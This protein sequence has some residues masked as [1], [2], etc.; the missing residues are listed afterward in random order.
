MIDITAPVSRPGT[1][2]RLRIWAKKHPL[3]AVAAAVAAVG[4]TGTAA[5][6]YWTISGAGQGSGQAANPT[7]AV[8]ITATIATPI[9][10]GGSHTV[11]T[12]Q[13]T[14]TNTSAVTVRTLTPTAVTAWNEV[15]MTTSAAACQTLLDSH[16]TGGPTAAA[17]DNWVSMAAV[18]VNT[19]VPAS[20]TNFALTG[21]TGTLA[22]YNDPSV[23]QDACKDKYFKVTFTNGG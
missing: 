5:F 20:S 3:L 18:A 22:F 11:N 6:A 9:Y 2:L 13:A 12:F 8:T 14:N 17:A 4:L 7:T 1:R 16:D 15:G 23:N 21:A 10:P 19:L